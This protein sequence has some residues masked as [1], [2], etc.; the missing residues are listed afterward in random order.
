MPF[1]DNFRFEY[2]FI[3]EVYRQLKLYTLENNT[4]DKA[5]NLNHHHFHDRLE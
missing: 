2:R 4:L 1:V 5:L 3:F